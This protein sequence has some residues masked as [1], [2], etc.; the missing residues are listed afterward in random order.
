MR[1]NPSSYR[2]MYKGV[3]V[4]FLFQDKF[5]TFWAQPLECLL[6]VRTTFDTMQHFL[7]HHSFRRKGNSF[8]DS[9]FLFF[10][11][12]KPYSR[13]IGKIASCM[14]IC[15]K[16]VLNQTRGSS[17]I[18]LILFSFSFIFSTHACNHTLAALI[19]TPFIYK[20]K[21][22]VCNIICPICSLT[23]SL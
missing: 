14:P 1:G 10:S 12:C 19:R 18:F 20:K 5:V 7:L 17:A 2:N 4:F 15:N 9:F 23:I 16:K 22:E 13:S 6:C 21:T 11:L 8:V 3:C